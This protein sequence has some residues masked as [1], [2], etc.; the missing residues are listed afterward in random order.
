MRKLSFFILLLTLVFYTK[1]LYAQQTGDL[2]KSYGIVSVPYSVPDNDQQNYADVYFRFAWN[3]K[4]PYKIAVQ[5]SN[6]AYANRKFKFA[7]KNVT[8]KKWSFWIKSII[9]VSEQLI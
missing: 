9:S 4:A 2:T 6:H 1:A 8:S 3:N 5:F 7:I